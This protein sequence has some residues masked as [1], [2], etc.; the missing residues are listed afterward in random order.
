[1][2]MARLPERCGQTILIDEEW[3][4]ISEQSEGEPVS[5][6]AAD[7]QAYVIYTSGSTG[8][9]KGVMVVHKGLSNLVEAQ[10]EAFGLGNQSRVLQF[11]SLSFDASVSEIFTALAAGGSLHVYGRESLMPGEGL[12]RAL[13]ED[14]I[15]T[16]TLPPTVLAALGEE[17]F[18]NLQTVIA[19]GEACGAEI[20]ERWG[21]VRRF[22]NAYGPTEATVC[23][24]IGECEAGSDRRPTIGRPI[25]NTRLYILD[26]E[27]NPVPLGVSGELYIGGAGVAR[28]Y[29][30]RP[31]LTADRFI[32]NPLDEHGARFYR[33]G[34]VCRYNA[35]GKVEFIGRFDEQVKV[36]GYRI[37]LG[38]IE[39]VL[40]E[41]P[42]V[43]QAAV[44]A[45]E[46]EAGL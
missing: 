40:S 31:E 26:K 18:I 30:G 41:Q 21:G 3:E 7:N 42:G 25:C 5:G 43:R 33:T 2:S 45:R 16:V 23:A 35:D 13:M 27:M 6:V 20:V 1:V 37:E 19:A 15:T 17:E 29:L 10:K 24:S 36:R 22:L 14:E 28:G 4:R 8:R 34:D 38:E 32:P 39:A 9:P 44:V 46:D 12:E 11:A